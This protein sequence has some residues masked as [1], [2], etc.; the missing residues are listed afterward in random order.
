MIGKL[1]NWSDYILICFHGEEIPHLATYFFFHWIFYLF[2]FQMLSPFQT[3]PPE[4][5]YS[6]PPPCFDKGAPCSPPIHSHL[7]A[8]VFPYT[9]PSQDQAPLLP[10][11][12]NKA[13]LCYIW[14]WSHGSLH[15]Y[16]LVGGLFPGRSVESGWLILLFFL[17]GCKPLQFLHSF[18]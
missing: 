4:T 9:W 14:G 13:I 1:S 3:P 15:M 2:T 18:L 12:P 7:L 8:L 16:S 10:L 5:L 11:M 17:W 6:I